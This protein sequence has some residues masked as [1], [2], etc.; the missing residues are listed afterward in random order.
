MPDNGKLKPCDFKTRGPLVKSWL[1]PLLVCQQDKLARQKSS[2]LHSKVAMKGLGR[3]N[4]VFDT[5]SLI[6]LPDIA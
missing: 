5:T 6:W 3:D 1:F 2:V 4:H